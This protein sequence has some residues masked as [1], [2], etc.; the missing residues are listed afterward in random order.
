MNVLFL[1]AS[2]YE[3]STKNLAI[4]DSFANMPGNSSRIEHLKPLDLYHITST[5][6]ILCQFDHDF[7]DT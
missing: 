7:R 6:Y 5:E 1:E 4:A 3:Q 2:I